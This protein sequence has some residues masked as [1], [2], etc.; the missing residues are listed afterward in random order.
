MKREFFYLVYMMISIKMNE[1]ILVFLTFIFKFCV[2]KS[3]FHILFV[4]GKHLK[5]FFSFSYRFIS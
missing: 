2:V 3:K 1:K 5:V 4:N